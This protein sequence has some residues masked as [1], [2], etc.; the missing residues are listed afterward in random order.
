LV[1]EIFESLK[2]KNVKSDQKKDFEGRGDQNQREHV[3]KSK[4]RFAESSQSSQNNTLE[5]FEALKSRLRKVSKSAEGNIEG[6]DANESPTKEAA[7]TEIDNCAEYNGKEKRSSTGSITNLKR[8]W[9]SQRN[10][11]QETGGMKS[12]KSITKESSE[13]NVSNRVIVEKPIVKSENPSLKSETDKIKGV[14]DHP[15][16]KTEIKTKFPVPKQKTENKP[17]K[18]KRVW[19][20]PGPSLENDKPAIPTKPLMTKKTNPI[21]ATPSQRVDH[22]SRSMRKKENLYSF[23][24]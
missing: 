9:E 8:M 24:Y 14:L 18:V 23:F 4:P 2:V 10:V 12:P 21:Y 1:S 7:S 17:V 6:S 13:S 16:E 5:N 3:E 19:P 11:Q 22:S 20:P 15:E